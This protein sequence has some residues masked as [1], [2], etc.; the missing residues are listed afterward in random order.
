MSLYNLP[1]EL[2]VFESN[3]NFFVDPCIRLDDAAE[4]SEMLCWFQVGELQM[5]FQDVAFLPSRARFYTTYQKTC[6]RA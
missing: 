3:V 6:G 5:G 2:F 1:K 4:V